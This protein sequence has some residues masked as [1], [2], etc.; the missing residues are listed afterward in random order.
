MTNLHVR[1]HD[2]HAARRTNGRRFLPRLEGVPDARC[3]RFIGIEVDVRVV[4]LERAD[5]NVDVALSDERG[6]RGPDER[7]LADR[8]VDV[9]HLS[10]RRVEDPHAQAF[11][12]LEPDVAHALYR[13]LPA[14][15]GSDGG[16]DL[17][18][19]DPMRRGQVHVKAD[20]RDHRTREGERR[21]EDGA[22]RAKPP[23]CVAQNASPMPKAIAIGTPKILE[24]TPSWVD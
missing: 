23:P 2:V 13:Q 16:F 17:P 12:P 18:R 9:E 20:A 8:A 7:D 22:E 4:G 19:R 1:G 6:V 10:S 11:D 3:P 15:L 5:L 24:C 14:Q 21:R